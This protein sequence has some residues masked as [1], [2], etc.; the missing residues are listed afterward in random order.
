MITRLLLLCL[1]TFLAACARPQSPSLYQYAIF[2]SFAA[3]EYA[4]KIP[5]SELKTHGDFGLGTTDGLTGEMIVLDGVFYLADAQCRL[6]RLDMSTLSPFAS[7]AF[8]K[9]DAKQ[10][11][12]LNDIP[13][14]IAELDARLPKG[15]FATARITARFK[16]LTIRSVPGYAKP[17]PPLGEALKTQFVMELDDVSGTLVGLRGPAEPTGAWVAG[18]HFHFVSSDGKAGGHVLKAVGLSGEA[19]WM[20]AKRFELELP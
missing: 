7:L 2:D 14:L 12:S 6:T 8:F 16:K 19:A 13:A 9:P 15:T 3:G 17:Y 18:W 10:S 4:G 11:I 5:L 20:A 1:L